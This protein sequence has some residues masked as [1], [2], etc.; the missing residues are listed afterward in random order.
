M[1]YFLGPHFTYSICVFIGLTKTVYP[2]CIGIFWGLY[3]YNFLLS[4]FLYN[5]TNWD[6]SLFLLHLPAC[7]CSFVLHLCTL[8]LKVEKNNSSIKVCIQTKEIS[9]QIIV[10]LHYKIRPLNFNYLRRNNWAKRFGSIVLGLSS[11]NFLGKAES[12]C[13][14]DF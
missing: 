12:Q 6:H 10:Q 3:P 8:L 7:K 9:K 13:T 14:R 4:N 11:A 1:E 2:E 5:S